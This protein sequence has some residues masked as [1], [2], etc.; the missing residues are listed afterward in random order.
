MSESIMVA[1]AI[2]RP[3]PSLFLAGLIPTTT[4]RRRRTTKKSPLFC[5]AQLPLADLAPPT[6]AAYGA[7]LLGGGVFACRHFS[8]SPFIEM[9]LILAWKCEMWLLSFFFFLFVMQIQG[10]GVK[11]LLREVS[12]GRSWWALWVGFFLS[13]S[14]A[15]CLSFVDFCLN[16]HSSDG[17]SWFVSLF[18]SWGAYVC[19]IWMVL[20]R[21]NIGV[22]VIKGKVYWFF[23]CLINIISFPPPI[24]QESGYPEIA[25]NK[26]TNKKTQD[27]VKR[28]LNYPLSR[29][30]LH[31]SI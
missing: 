19:V 11:G 12:L 9:G 17:C 27:Q 26:N 20:S 16:S 10:R 22:K 1:A 28:S 6:A 21:W 7:L 18:F 24:T 2:L 25:K 13:F 4:A 14:S 31:K 3:T 29:N 30:H 15:R 23:S 8:A 5:S